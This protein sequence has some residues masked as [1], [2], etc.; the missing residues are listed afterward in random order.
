MIHAQEL[1][2]SMHGQLLH[3]SQIAK[4]VAILVL[5]ARWTEISSRYWYKASDLLLDFA[6]PQHPKSQSVVVSVHYLSVS[7]RHISFERASQRGDESCSSVQNETDGAKQ[8]CHR[9]G[10]SGGSMSI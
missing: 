9:N 7:I 3:P 1:L 6:R 4:K 10:E 2:V 8:A 5:S